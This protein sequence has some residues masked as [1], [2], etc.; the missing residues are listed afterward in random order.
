MGSGWTSWG[1][2]VFLQDMFELIQLAGSGL[3]SCLSAQVHVSYAA[4]I[5]TLPEF[6]CVMNASDMED[7]QFS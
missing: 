3:C 4:G 5:D 6:C 7:S 2:A 1:W